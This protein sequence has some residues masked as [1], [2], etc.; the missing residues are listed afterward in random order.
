MAEQPLAHI[1]IVQDDTELLEVMKLVLED[2]GYAV[3]VADS[4]ERA[5]ETIAGETVDLV[6]LDVMMGEMSGLD[7]ARQIRLQTAATRTVIA[8]YTDAEEASVRKRS[9]D[10]DLVIPKVDDAEALLELIAG[11]LA[12]RSLPGDANSGPETMDSAIGSRR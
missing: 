10:F 9:A 4:A 7:V 11:A 8:L 2:G 12:S 5:L 1:L 6:V 3:S